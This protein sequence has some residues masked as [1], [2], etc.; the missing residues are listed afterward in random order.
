MFILSNP[1]YLWFLL[2]ISF[3]M[4]LH[5]FH[6]NKRKN[7]TIKFS[8]FGL[9]KEISKHPRDYPKMIIRIVILILLV[10]AV[11][12]AIYEQPTFTTNMSFVISVDTSNALTQEEFESI[13]QETIN[14]INDLPQGV[15]IGVV[16]FSEESRIESILITNKNNI[17]STV[18]NLELTKNENR[19]IQDS[20]IDS[21][22]LLVKEEERIVTARRQTT[23]SPREL[24]VTATPK[25]IVIA[26]SQKNIDQEIQNAITL[27][28]TNRINIYTLGIN[29]FNSEDNSFM[30]SLNLISKSTEGEYFNIVNKIALEQAYDRIS[31]LTQG[32]IVYQ[33]SDLF[34]ITVIFLLILEWVLE[35]IRYGIIP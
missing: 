20:I 23:L 5:F 10:L 1:S 28:N 21:V 9:A 7:K 12:G 33:L 18:D 2:V 31:S 27:A 24:F 34:I 3:L 13:K 32:K 26:T 14:F 15:N 6:F 29:M 8:N 35:Y 30:K 4:F 17:I 11:S 19:N 25:I 16:T 22:D